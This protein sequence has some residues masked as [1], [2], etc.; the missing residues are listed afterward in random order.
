MLVSVRCNCCPQDDPD[1]R[2]RIWY[3]DPL[4]FGY[5][6]SERPDVQESSGPEGG[7]MLFD[8]PPWRVIYS[9][10]LSMADLSHA[11]NVSNNK[12]PAFGFPVLHTFF[13][14]NRTF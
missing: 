8:Y 10:V 3:F 14:G 11:H 12:C 7:Y 2:T 1:L 9:C 5:F 4:D 6:L 13:F